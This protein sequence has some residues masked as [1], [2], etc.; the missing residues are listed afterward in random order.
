M[1]LPADER[2]ERL[3]TRQGLHLLRVRELTLGH[4]AERRPQH[5]AIKPILAVEMVVDRGL[6]DAR[7]G[8]DG[9]N[10]G[11]VIAAFGEQAFGGLHDAVAG[12]FGRSRHNLSGNSLSLAVSFSNAGLNSK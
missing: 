2:A 7:L 11:A 10:A 3:L 8:D 1:Q 4:A 9:A 6:I 12:D 5:L